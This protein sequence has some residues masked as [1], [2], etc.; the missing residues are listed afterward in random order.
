MIEKKYSVPAISC[1]H[2]VHTIQMELAEMETVH[3]VH[4]DESSKVVT[5]TMNDESAESGVLNMLSEIG[6]PA[7]KEIQ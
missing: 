7:T 4:A 1:K 2:C 6:Y 3:T 5:V